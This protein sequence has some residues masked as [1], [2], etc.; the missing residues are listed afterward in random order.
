MPRTNPIGVDLRFAESHVTMKAVLS[1]G[2]VYRLASA[3]LTVGSIGNPTEL[4]SLT[5]LPFGG[6]VPGG[7]YQV[8]YTFVTPYGETALSPTYNLVFAGTRSI[9]LFLPTL[10]AGVTGVR[11]YISEASPNGTLRLI[12][13]TS[14][15]LL[16]VTA[17]PTSD[18]PTP[19]L[20]STAGELYLAY[21]MRDSEVRQT[22]LRTADQ[23]AVD[24]QNVDREIGLTVND[25]ARTLSGADVTFSKVFSSDGSIWQSK[26]LLI[27]IITSAEVDENVVAIQVVSDIAPNVAFIGTRP[28]QENCPLVFKGRACGYTG[29]LTT[30]NK[31]YDSPDG[32]A[33]RQRQ[34]RFGGAKDKGELERPVTLGQD[35]FGEGDNPRRR[36]PLFPD[37]VNG[38]WNLPFDID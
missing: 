15:T 36:R 27:G 12:S 11:W 10:P 4:P 37:P 9:R 21:L 8:G 5:T 2:T 18:Q 31:E 32:C 20:N 1:D 35:G 23:V 30:C 13:E 6:Q 24:V 14:D 25:V 7:Q 16:I 29:P 22:L 19:P 34:H 33:G 17:L 26:V 28:V 3:S 38:R